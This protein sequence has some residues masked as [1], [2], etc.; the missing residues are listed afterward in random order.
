MRVDAAKI[1]RLFYPQVPLVLSAA[2][3]GRVSGMPVVSYASISGKPPLIGV[4][5]SPLAFTYRLA[6]RAGAFSLCLLG[7]KRLGAIE[8]LATLSGAMLR[9]KLTE[10]GL[11]YIPGKTTGAP[12]ID[13]AEAAIE[14]RLRS[15]TK[16]G[17]HVLL[18]GRV[19]DSSV[20]EAFAD[21]W[22][23]RSYRPILYT[24]WRDGMTT[25]AGEEGMPEP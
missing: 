15:R 7:S 11:G 3:R 20:S 2:C 14:C 17:D 18:V 4:A 10:A 24:G 9:D 21:F 5:C 1:H 13:G 6:A 19:V 23:F 8:R 16:L 25:Y 22:D 12:L